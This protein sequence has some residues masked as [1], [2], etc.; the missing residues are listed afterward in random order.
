MRNL[1]LP[2]KHKSK[3]CQLGLRKQTQLGYI[4]HSFEQNISIENAKLLCLK[5]LKTFFKILTFSSF[6][7]IRICIHSAETL[8][9]HGCHF[10]MIK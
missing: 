1:I 2:H 7:F 9:T 6:K 8:G 5:L 4:T 3:E 10:E